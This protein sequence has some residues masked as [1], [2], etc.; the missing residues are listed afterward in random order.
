MEQGK[1]LQLKFKDAW[2]KMEIDLKHILEFFFS[3]FIILQK[4]LKDLRAIEFNKPLLIHNR[5]KNKI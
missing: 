2:L 5:I 3:S 4:T 1:L